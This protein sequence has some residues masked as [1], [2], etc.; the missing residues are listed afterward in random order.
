MTKFTFIAEDELDLDA[1]V[2]VE[3][4]TDVWLDAF[5]KFLNLM[6]ASGFS[7]KDGAALY[8]PQISE[9]L[10]RDSDRDYLLFDSDLVENEEVAKCCG[11]CSTMKVDNDHSAW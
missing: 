4:E 2:T 6:R 11:K 10:F 8:V 1:R 7:I 3:F 9:T 5:P